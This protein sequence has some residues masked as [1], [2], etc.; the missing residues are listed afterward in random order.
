[1][2][3]LDRTISLKGASGNTYT[4]DVYTADTNWRD[5]VAC[6]YYVSKRDSSGNHTNLYVGETE[7]LKSRHLDHHKQQCFER[8]GYNAISILMESNATKRL[9]I[10]KDLVRALKPPCNA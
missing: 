8:N 2:S 4:F 1:M 9:Q 3:N 5:S 6:V 10:E 7:D